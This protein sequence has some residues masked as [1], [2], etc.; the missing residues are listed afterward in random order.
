MA[1]AG[2]ELVDQFRPVLLGFAVL[3][4][5][6]AYGILAAGDSDEEEDI[7]DNAIVKVGIPCNSYLSST[8]FALWVLH[9]LLEWQCFVSRIA[10]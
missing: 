7:N 9:D 3:L 1:F 6:S 8:V 10:A 5:Y 2:V 4:L